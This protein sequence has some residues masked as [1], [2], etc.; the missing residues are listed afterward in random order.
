MLM[1]IAVYDYKRETVGRTSCIGIFANIGHRYRCMSVDRRRKWVATARSA[2]VRF[3][4]LPQ[5]ISCERHR[6]TQRG[7]QSGI[8]RVVFL[9]CGTTMVRRTGYIGYVGNRSVRF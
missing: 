2:L 4:G 8:L 6:D 1:T 7:G 9:V 5:T 3:F